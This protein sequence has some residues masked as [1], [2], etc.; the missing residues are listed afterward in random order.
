[1]T[2][3]Y[4]VPH[5]GSGWFH[6][7][8]GVAGFD[9]RIIRTFAGRPGSPVAVVIHRGRRSG[10]RHRTPVVAVPLHEGYLVSLPYGTDG[11]WVHNMAYREPRRMICSSLNV[12]VGDVQGG[13]G[14]PVQRRRATYLPVGGHMTVHASP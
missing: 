4:G 5:S 8:D 7:T 14:R 13:Q 1:M 6:G 10:R 9:T 2:W 11:D 12:G 3:Q